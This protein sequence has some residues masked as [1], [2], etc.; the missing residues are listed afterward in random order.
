MKKIKRDAKQAW[1]KNKNRRAGLLLKKNILSLH[2]IVEYPAPEKITSNGAPAITRFF[3]ADNQQSVYLPGSVETYQK[4]VPIGSTI[5]VT[6]PPLNSRK[7]LEDVF[8]DYISI[9]I[10]NQIFG[11]DYNPEMPL[12]LALVKLNDKGRPAYIFKDWLIV[13]SLLDIENYP[14]GKP[15]VTTYGR[16]LVNYYLV[17]LPFCQE[18]DP[19]Q[20]PEELRFINKKWNIK[21]FEGSLSMLLMEKKIKPSECDEYLDNGYFM[22]DYGE[23]CGGTLTRKAV[24]PD[25]KI[26][27]RRKELLKKYEGQLEKDPRLMAVIENELIAM[28]RNNLKDDP[29]MDFFGGQKDAVFSV[30]RKRQYSSMGMLEKFGGAKGDY[31][32]VEDSLAEGISKEHFAMLSNEARRGFYNRAVDTQVAGVDTKLMISVFQNAKITA[33]DCGTKQCLSIIIRPEVKNSFLGQYV[34]ISPGK[35]EQLTRD[36]MENYINRPVKIR[37][38][39]YCKQPDGYCMTCAGE[40]FKALH[41]TNP[42]VLTIDVGAVF[43]AMSMKAMHGVKIDIMELDTLNDFIL[44]P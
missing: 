25:P 17:A 30:E 26:I 21:G 6:N 1:Y 19:E 27:Q 12:T 28:D 20:I 22:G 9:C 18:K 34:E 3:T 13:D 29:S 23:I 35:Y 8:K 7:M 44:N 14:E 31:I 32:F 33:E 42:G 38:F 5:T 24:V 39:M 10:G 2:S 4:P 40:K 16:Y 15:F 43:M 11:V 37:S 36:N 41:Y